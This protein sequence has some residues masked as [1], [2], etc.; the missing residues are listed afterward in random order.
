MSLDFVPSK[1]LIDELIKRHDNIIVVYASIEDGNKKMMKAHWQYN[2]DKM[3]IARLV[4][5]LMVEVNEC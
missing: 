5:F 2:K 1:D 4:N 3:N